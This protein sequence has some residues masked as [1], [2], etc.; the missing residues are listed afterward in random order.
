MHENH[1]WYFH[2]SQPH[3]DITADT[4]FVI[5]QTKTHSIETHIIESMCLFKPLDTHIR[6]YYVTVQY[7]DIKAS[8]SVFF[9]RTSPF[10]VLKG[11]LLLSTVTL[12][13]SFWG[14]WVI[15]G[16]SS[17]GRGSAHLSWLL[18]SSGLSLAAR[19]QW[20]WTLPLLYGQA[21]ESFPH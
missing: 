2:I 3:C 9:L 11:I 19:D 1:C 6:F 5:I 20:L 17:S 21:K 14:F 10:R 18:L 13:A 16:S 8:L 15:I 4:N 7:N 12:L